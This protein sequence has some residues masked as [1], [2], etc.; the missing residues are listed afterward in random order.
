[1]NSINEQLMNKNT[2]QFPGGYFFAKID[3][4][5]I[6]ILNQGLRELGIA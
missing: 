5:A 4:I 6:N 3:L 2:R 1:M